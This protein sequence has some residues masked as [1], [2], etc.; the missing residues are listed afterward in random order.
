MAAIYG[1]DKALLAILKS[2]E[3][4][5]AEIAIERKENTVRREA[6]GVPDQFWG[7]GGGQNIFSRL[8]GLTP[9]QPETRP[10]IA[11]TRAR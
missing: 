11:A 8:F 3:R 10:R 6:L 5:I 9:T 4:K 1:R 7:S 2:D